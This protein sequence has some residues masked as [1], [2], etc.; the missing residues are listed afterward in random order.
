MLAPECRR[1]RICHTH[2]GGNH[3]VQLS[4]MMD[5]LAFSDTAAIVSLSRSV[6]WDYTPE[7][8]CVFLSAGVLFGYRREDGH[9]VSSAGVFTYGNLA[10]IGVVMVHPDFQGRGLGRAML[11]RCLDEVGPVPT[12]LVSTAEGLR[13]Y[14]SLGFKTVAHIH[15]LISK[16]SLQWSSEPACRGCIANLSDTDLMDVVL[17]DERVMGANRSRFLTSRFPLLH[18]GVALRSEDGVLYG[19]GMAVRRQDLLI[20]GPLVAPEHVS[21]LA[22]IRQLTDGWDGSVRIDVPSHQAILLDSLV[23]LGMHEEE[24]PPILMLNG[25]SLPG[26]RESLY[27]IAAQA[28]G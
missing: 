20:I 13:L 14:T 5:K 9:L 24:R 26:Q 27:A 3:V 2:E 19:Y 12:M 15:K 23:R 21:A 1:R 25:H 8:V 10:S 16:G 6:G 28:F 17:L 7:D 22:M 4:L 11:R 18:S